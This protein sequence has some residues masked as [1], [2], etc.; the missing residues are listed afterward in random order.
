MKKCY[1]LLFLLL[2]SAFSFAQDCSNGRYGSPI[3]SNVSSIKNIKYGQNY[4]QDGTTMEELYLDVYYPEGDQATDR[5]VILLA[6]GG[7]FVGGQRQDL[8][9]DCERF[10]KLGYV[11]VTMSYRL[12]N[13]TPQVLL[14]TGLEF[15]KEVARSVH[16]MKAAI[17]FLRKSVAEDGNPY[18]I[19]PNLI[20]AG[21][22]SAGAILANHVAYMDDVSEIPADLVSYMNEQGGLEGN[23]GNAGYPSNPQMIASMCGAINDTAWIT[24]GS[25]PYVG[26]HN[27]GDGVVP[28]IY[29]QP[30]I[31]LVIPV[32][33]YG[34]SLMYRQALSQNIP[35]RYKMYPGD[36]HCDFPLEDA[37][38]FVTSF[39]RDQLCG[40][41]GISSMNQYNFSVYPNPANNYLQLQLGNT[42][43]QGQIQIFDMLGKVVL[44]QE[45]K[46]SLQNKIDISTFNPGQYVIQIIKENGESGVQKFVKY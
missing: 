40:S 31:G 36:G 8:A 30:N 22:Y 16:D 42:L 28:N 13:V 17:R 26:I 44:K 11:A 20:I 19:N 23:S 12:L 15:K 2:F 3:F 45:I 33:L 24:A 7:S 18:G 5:V 9:A 4:K 37:F 1:A 41:T 43:T 46:N 35:A 10:A 25:V 29:G 14:N 32:D 27:T 21:G 38:N 39:L 6:H 34:D